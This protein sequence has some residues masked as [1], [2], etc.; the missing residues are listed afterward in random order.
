MDP[1]QKY[2]RTLQPSKRQ[3]YESPN[4]A[5]QGSTFE[6][7]KNEI[8]EMVYLRTKLYG[9]YSEGEEFWCFRK[10]KLIFAH[11]II[12]NY[13]QPIDY[14]GQ[15]SVASKKE[16]AAKFSPKGDLIFIHGFDKNAREK[17]VQ[18][19]IMQSLDANLRELESDS[20]ELTSDPIEWKIFTQ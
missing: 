15:R 9:E 18:I 10:L 6:V 4:L 17:F 8:G 11:E 3:L 2:C 7:G 1:D 13:N 16:R 14:G 5:S 12:V 19:K 20:I